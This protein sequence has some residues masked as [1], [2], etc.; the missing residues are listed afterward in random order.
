MSASP[1]HVRTQEKLVGRVLIAAGVLC[2]VA[3]G[4]LLWARYGGVVFNDM[5]LSALAWCF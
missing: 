4:A 2:L 1:S 3:T 5:V